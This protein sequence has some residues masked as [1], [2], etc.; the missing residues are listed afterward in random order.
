MLKGYLHSV[1]TMGLFDGPG[2][3]T[4]FFLQGCPLRCTYCHNPDSQPCRGGREITVSEVL[5]TVRRYRNYYASDGGVTFSGGEPLLQGAFLTAACRALKAEGIH[6]AIDSSGFGDPRYYPEL[7]PL[8]DLL[9][10]DVKAFEAE[11]FTA[12]TEGNFQQF[13][14][15]ISQLES[16][17]FKGKVRIRHVMLPGVSDNRESMRALVRTIQPIAQLIEAIEILPY[18][19][20]GVEKYTALGKSYKLAGVPPMDQEEAKA[21]EDYANRCFR[22]SLSRERTR[23]IA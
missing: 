22:Q 19:T 6:I 21:Y 15:F 4:V 14:N 8:V 18:H 7:L 23:E 5:A 16:W 20:L 11:P 3:R 9:L 2:I 1:E 12:L 10:L 13:Q 17:G